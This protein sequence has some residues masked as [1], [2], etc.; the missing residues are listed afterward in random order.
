M[1]FSTRPSA[2]FVAALCL[3]FRPIDL[4]IHIPAA[5]TSSHLGWIPN[6]WS[7]H[8]A[9][10]ENAK[11]GQ[12]RGSIG[13]FAFGHAS[14]LLFLNSRPNMPHGST[15]VL[16]YYTY[17]PRIIRLT[18]SHAHNLGQPLVHHFSVQILGSYTTC[19]CV[20]RSDNRNASPPVE[21]TP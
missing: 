15:H 8:T 6:C 1:N 13:R 20:L 7:K 21:N 11:I 9:A 10:N 4:I 19:S 12:P 14:S 18:T 16:V 17:T 2:R 3:S 5:R